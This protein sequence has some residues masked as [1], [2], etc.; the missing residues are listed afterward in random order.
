[1][2]LTEQEIAERVASFSAWHYRFDLDGVVTPIVDERYVTRHAQR[3]AYFFDPLVEAL[4]GSLAGKRVL[5]LGCNAGFWSL[6]AA[7]AGCEHVLG[8]DGRQMHVDQAEL[9]FEV[10]GVPRERYEFR[11]ADIYDLDLSAEGPFD[12]VL[13]LGLLYHVSKPMELFEWIDAINS[14]LLVIDTTL[15]GFPGSLLHMKRENLDDPR[16][17]VDYEIVGYPTRQAVIDMVRVFGYTVRLLRPG[18]SDWTGS[19]DYRT[20]MRRAYVCSK[21]TDISAVGTEE[22]NG[23]VRQLFDPLR[24]AEYI[25]RKKLGGG[26]V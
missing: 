24:Y 16:S 12:L 23:P 5:D 9:V 14:D 21:R 2:T 19:R 4:G 10:N 7:E 8:V 17:G 18:F 13:C 26:G 22:S 15:V 11:L 20:G 1:M 3:K 25:L 6:A